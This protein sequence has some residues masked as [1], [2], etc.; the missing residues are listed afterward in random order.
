MTRLLLAVFGAATLAAVPAGYSDS[1]VTALA[2]LT[3][4]AAVVYAGEHVSGRLTLWTDDEPVRD[5][6]PAAVPYVP[7]TI[8]GA[9]IETRAALTRY[10]AQHGHH[11]AG[12]TCLAPAL[13]RLQLAIDTLPD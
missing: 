6:P 13:D 12:W 10:E 8:R 4:A 7:A 2:L 11:E 5:L 1:A 9:L 3:V